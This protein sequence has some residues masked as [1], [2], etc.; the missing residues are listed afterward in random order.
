M[1]LLRRR[2]R[3]DFQGERALVLGIEDDADRV[4][5]I[6]ALQ[7][8]LQKGF[9][10]QSHI[11]LVRLQWIRVPRPLGCT[12]KGH[13]RLNGDGAGRERA[14]VAIVQVEVDAEAGRCLARFALARFECG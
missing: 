1:R 13:A 11:R 2:E 4:P 3:S 12:P 10:S 5:C 14:L 8:G 6:E 7:A 9:L